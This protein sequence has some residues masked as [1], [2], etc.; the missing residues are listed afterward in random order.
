[1]RYQDT[2]QSLDIVVVDDSS[3]SRKAIVNILEKHNYTVVGEAASARQA[4]EIAAE[5]K[6]DLFIIDVVMPGVS[7]I[8][9]AKELKDHNLAKYYILM[10]SLK[11][12]DIVI[13]A[14]SSGAIDFLQKP[15]EPQI[16]LDSVGK[17]LVEI[18]R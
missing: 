1:M 15:F 18:N 16:L 6:V 12:E 11:S 7:G 2:K 17:V 9:L 10:S 5:T 14:I 13:S 3:M 8:E 4:L